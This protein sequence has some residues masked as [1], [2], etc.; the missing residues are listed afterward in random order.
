[1]LA[2]L[3]ILLLSIVLGELFLAGVRLLQAERPPGSAALASPAGQWSAV[4]QMSARM[5]A[6]G[7]R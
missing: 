5:R 6:M 2:A 1:V 3:G 4:R 7:L